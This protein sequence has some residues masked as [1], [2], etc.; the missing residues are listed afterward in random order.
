MHAC[1]AAP[2][3][4]SVSARRVACELSSAAGLGVTALGA[5]RIIYCEAPAAVPLIAQES[6][7]EAVKVH[8]KGHGAVRHVLTAVEPGL[9]AD[10]GDGRLQV[11]RHASTQNRPRQQQK[12]S[13]L[14][15]VIGSTPRKYSE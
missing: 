5:S 11:Q 7:Y 4:R 8:F 10:G 3:A 14:A 13:P 1:P 2:T 12:G 6:S 15:S 9:Q